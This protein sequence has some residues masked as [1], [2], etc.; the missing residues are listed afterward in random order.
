MTPD[1]SSSASGRRGRWVPNCDT[2]GSVNSPR[3][4]RT[5]LLLTPV[6]IL[7]FAA[8]IWPPWLDD[9]DRVLRIHERMIHALVDGNYE[10]AWNC[11][12]RRSRACVEFA[13]EL[14]SPLSRD[15]VW[16]PEKMFH[17]TPEQAGRMS[18]ESIF[19]ESQE[20]FARLK[21][22]QRKEAEDYL[23]DLR[24]AAT[25]V[26][27]RRAK[28][29]CLSDRAIPSIDLRNRD[30]LRGLTF[31]YVREDGE[32]R[33][34]LA[35]LTP[36]W[37]DLLP[38]R[39]MPSTLARGSL[40]PDDVDIVI[41]V[42]APGVSHAAFDHLRGALRH[43]RR[44]PPEDTVV[45][46]DAAASTSWGAVIRVVD[47]ARLEGIETIHHAASAESGPLDGV[48]VNGVPVR[49]AVPEAA[50][51]APARHRAVGRIIRCPD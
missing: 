50:F 44:D 16:C 37:P 51:A 32:W 5:V 8:Y 18:P 35:T 1:G 20:R 42:G 47:A 17:L 11:R 10:E 25:V 4:T 29:V 34:L 21:P 48:R 45:V 40:R 2:N 7:A 6:V 30:G 22:E 27:K 28:V 36:E 26:E 13:L 15:W 23:S 12:S 24:I 3:V 19:I 31:H 9:E 14:A 39:Y 41:E 43:L 38:G 33:F 49:R 46:V